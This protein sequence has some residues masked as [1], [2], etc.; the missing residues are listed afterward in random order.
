[1]TSE[2]SWTALSDDPNHPQAKRLARTRL[3]ELRQVH[4][5]RDLLGFIEE[6]V[7]GKHVLDIGIVSHSARYFDQPDWRHGRIA[8]AATS[9]LGIDI[10]EPLLL[11]LAARGYNVRRADATSDTDLGSRHDV[12][13]I[14]DV[15]EHVE[16]AVALLRFAAR[17]LAPGGR[18][19]ATTPNP[20]SRKFYRQ[21]RREGVMVVNLDHLAWITPTMAMEL[22]RRAGIALCAYHLAKRLSPAARCWKRLAWKIEPVEYS[23]PDYVYEFA[24]PEARADAAVG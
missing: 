18:I 8:K 21:F 17:H 5:E 19:Y 9:C 13:F 11:E 16:N 12:V 20:F 2:P 22:A 1:M 7:R 24:A 4:A 23:F 15:I 3:A 6:L 10:L 14:G